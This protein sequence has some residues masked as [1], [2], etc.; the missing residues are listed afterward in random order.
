MPLSVI[1]FFVIFNKIILFFYL[2]FNVI[3]IIVSL[4]FTI[5]VFNIKLLEK[6]ILLDFGLLVC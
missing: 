3:I 4:Q 1:V 2:S 6:Y 5:Y